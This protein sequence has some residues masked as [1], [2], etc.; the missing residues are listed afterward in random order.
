MFRLSSLLVLAAAWED[1]ILP[2]LSGRTGNPAALIYIQGADI[3]TSSYVEITNQ[4]QRLAPF[5]LYVAIP[6][7]MENVAAIPGTLSSGVKRA[8]QLLADAGMPANTKLFYAGHS[9]GGAMVVDY[10][11]NSDSTSSGLILHGA[12]ITRT[13]KTGKTA[14]GRPQVLYPVPSIT[15]GGEL[16]GL[17]RLTRISESLYSQ[18]SFAENPTTAGHYM[19]VT[20]VAGMSHGQ[21]ANS[22]NLPKFVTNNDL[23]P[24][25]PTANAVYAAAQDSANFMQAVLGVTTWSTLDG[26]SKASAAL[27]QPIVNAFNMEGYWNFLP[28]CLCETP[29]EYGGLQYGTCVSN[30]TCIGGSPWTSQY[31]QGVM[32]S[33]VS[34]LSLDATDSFHYVTEEHPSCHLPH[35]HGSTENNANPGNGNSPPLCPSPNPCHLT[36]TT[37]TEAFYRSSDTTPDTGFHPNSAHELKTKLKSRQAIYEAAGIPN[38]NLT[39]SDMPISAG[40]VADLCGEINQ[41]SLD[42][43]F[44]NAAANA[45]NRYSTRGKPLKVGPDHTTCLPG[46]CWIES[47]LKFVDKGTYVSVE[48]TMMATPN[49]NPYPCGEGQLIPCDAGFHYCKVVFLCFFF[50]IE[51]FFSGCS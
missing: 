17:C 31:S 20:V 44:K 16:D 43:A 36:I 33:G 23:E 18:V 45:Q 8:K 6:Q 41:A 7:M 34:G 27:T 19:P 22:S 51:I 35:I 39:L 21:F 28:P 30:A 5:P 11:A 2:P 38:V 42:W 10:V 13:Y 32:G 40:G 9:L 12:F 1:I 49:Y 25:I 46:P 47:E 15:I 29:D 24:E 14:E 3:P 26:R 48:S 37:V 50:L 4:I